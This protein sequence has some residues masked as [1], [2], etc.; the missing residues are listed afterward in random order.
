MCVTQIC[1]RGLNYALCICHSP[2]EDPFK[3][4]AANDHHE[5]QALRNNH[6]SDCELESTLAAKC[7]AE[8]C[9]KYIVTVLDRVCFIVYMLLIVGHQLL[10][11][12]LP[13]VLR[14]VDDKPLSYNMKEEDGALFY[15]TRLTN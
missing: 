7:N 12:P 8:T 4:L 3:R 2:H 14:S 13:L 11:F 15:Y 6:R 1:C 10:Y 5:S 9:W